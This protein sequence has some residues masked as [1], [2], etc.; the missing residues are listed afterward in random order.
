MNITIEGA[1]RK[2]HKPVSS[3]SIKLQ[4]VLYYYYIMS[5]PSPKTY[6]IDVDGT[7]VAN[8]TDEELEVMSKNPSEVQELLPNVK[9]FFLSL[10][11]D[12]IVIITTARA[13][14]FRE[15][16]ENMLKFHSIKYSHCI[17]DLHCGQRILINDTVNM[18]YQKAIAI[19]VMR[20]E[21]LGSTYIYD[22]TF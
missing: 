21:G 18:L 3:N 19:N 16:T 10:P 22:S 13:E 17:M 6:F 2:L 7:I 4:I 11:D 5:V 1:K 15:L 8:K 12:D 9:H 20:D 14:K